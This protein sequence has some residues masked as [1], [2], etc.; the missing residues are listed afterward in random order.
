MPSSEDEAEMQKDGVD[1]ITQMFEEE[2]AEIRRIYEDMLKFEKKGN[3]SAV[4][5]RYQ[6]VLRFKNGEI[7]HAIHLLGA[8]AANT[9]GDVSATKERLQRALEIEEVADTQTWLQSINASYATVDISVSKSYEVI[10]TLEAV[11]MPF[12]P[13]QQQAIAYAQEVLASGERFKGMLPFGEYTMGAA[14]FSVQKQDEDSVQKFKISEKGNA[15]KKAKEPKESKPK[16][17]NRMLSV[18][19]QLNIGFS[20]ANAGA[21][22]VAQQAD[23]FG[24][25]GT[26]VSL[27]MAVPV[28]EYAL[29]TEMGYHGAFSGADDA[30]VIVDNISY[31]TDTVGT[32]YHGFFLSMAAQMHLSSV[33]LSLGPIVEFA[34]VQTQGFG[35]FANASVEGELLAAG[36]V[37]GASYYALDL[38]DSYKAGV[39]TQLGWQSDSNRGY[40]WGQIAFTIKGSKQ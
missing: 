29:L 6:E 36:V 32:Q 37:T 9:R 22:S 20:G 15:P 14:T 18:A 38:T 26:R 33:D 2:Q 35:Q 25:K 28:G 39:T 27:G 19:P 1:V 24:G 13:D 21:S 8:Q 16:D 34:K 30:S 17:G 3:W 10:P 12:L 11:E 4:E 40:S 31:T 7:Q 5:K 23:P